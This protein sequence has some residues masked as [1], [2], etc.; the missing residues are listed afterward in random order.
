MSGRGALLVLGGG[1]H[2][3]VVADLAA[4]A[5]FRVV[6]FLDDERP[7][8]ALGDAPHLG[9]IAGLTAAAGRF[10]GAS[11]HAAVGA[12]ALREAW[13]D[14]ARRAGLLEGTVVAPSADVSPS[15]SLGPG[16]F[17]GARAVV[18][19]RASVGRGVLVNTSAV[20]EHDAV[21]E[22]FAHLA[23]GAIVCGGARVGRG[24]RVDAGAVVPANAVV[25]AGARIAR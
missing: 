25:E 10:P 9:P 20:V 15:A 21:V 13:L 23:T 11:A 4:R 6:G 17:V 18:A 24:A 14:A 5:G 19:A 12:A 22:D 16:A 8:S 3:A 1:G 2:A 7:A